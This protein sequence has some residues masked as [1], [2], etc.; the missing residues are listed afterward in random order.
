MAADGA[1]LAVAADLDQLIASLIG[2]E[3][4]GLYE[5]ADAD[6]GAVPTVSADGLDGAL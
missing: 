2:R 6:Y 3:E 4:E 5:A 1:G